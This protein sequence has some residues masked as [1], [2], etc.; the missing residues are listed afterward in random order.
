M[1]TPRVD[2]ATLQ[3]QRCMSTFI[4]SKLIGRETG[5]K[6]EVHRVGRVRARAAQRRFQGRHWRSLARAGRDVIGIP[7]H[8]AGRAAH[9][10]EAVGAGEAIG[11]DFTF[12]RYLAINRARSETRKNARTIS[13]MPTSQSRQTATHRLSI[14]QQFH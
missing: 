1:V 5:C 4:C 8:A 9:G 14:A 7:R 3:H 10:S 13:F 6:C 2:D 12:R 11:H